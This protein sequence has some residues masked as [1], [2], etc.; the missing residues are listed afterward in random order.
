[1]AHINTSLR[2]ILLGLAIATAISAAAHADVTVEE[3]LS[4]NGAGMMKM[5][6]MTGRTVTTISG[7]RARTDTDLTFESALV[8]TFARGVGQSTDIV[9]LDE[10]KVYSLNNKK[11]TYTE[12][13]FAD[14]RAKMQES[15]QKMQE[16]QA[17]QQ[18]TA[19]GV[20][21]SQC[22]WSEPKA[23]V[24]RSGEKASIAGFQAERVTITATQACKNKEN[25]EVCEFG[26]SLDQWMAPG[27]EAS[28]ETLA[29]NR[30][31]AEKLG[32][33]TGT[34]KEFAERAQTLFSRYQGIWNEV[35]TK[36]R[37]VKGN[38]VKSSFALGVGGPQCGSAQEAQQSNSSASQPSLGGALGGAIGGLFNKKKEQAPPPATTP[39]PAMANGLIA[40][41]TVST[42]MIS[43][44]RDAAGPQAFTVPADYK[45]TK[46]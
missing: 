4:V 14:L 33:T 9:L 39:P 42:E 24:K 26:L 1:M 11:K 21:D 22:E 37:D 38:P 3:S 12:T 23:E 16:A 13:T 5:A 31:Y 44:N 6:N 10:D 40:L 18:Q 41:M 25:G 20:D 7:R 46:D 35:A 36:M 45:K 29:Y 19:S 34:S 43:V 30:A 17:S 28:S 27:F 2:Q 15:M 32:L 8:R